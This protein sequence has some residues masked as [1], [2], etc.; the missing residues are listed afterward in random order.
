MS[1]AHGL[2]SLTGSVCLFLATMAV[3]GLSATP[4]WGQ[5]PPDPTSSDSFGNTAGGSNA[6]MSN[7][8]DTSGNSTDGYYNTAFGF[9][10]LVNNTVGQGNTASGFDA[11]ASN[12]SGKHN[13]ASGSFALLSSG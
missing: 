3:I 11:L 12:T 10:A 9:Q 8:P 1:K 5:Q 13:T 7:T 6:L 2:K 4:S